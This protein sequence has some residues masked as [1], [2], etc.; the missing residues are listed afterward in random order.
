MKWWIGDGDKQHTIINAD[1]ENAAMQIA[2]DTFGPD[3]IWK[4]MTDEQAAAMEKWLGQLDDAQ[5]HVNQ[6][7]K[8]LTREHNRIKAHYKR[9]DVP[10]L[11]FA[12]LGNLSH[13]VRTDDAT[14]APFPE[15]LDAVMAMV[16]RRRDWAECIARLQELIW[17]GEDHAGS[18]IGFGELRDLFHEGESEPDP[19]DILDML[20]DWYRL[21]SAHRE[22]MD[23]MVLAMHATRPAEL[24]INWAEY[25][26]YLLCTI[27][28]ACE[29]DENLVEELGEIIDAAAEV[30]GGF[31]HFQHLVWTYQ[32]IKARWG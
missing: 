13:C 22:A 5:D 10:D 27:A 6:L 30:Q 21:P 25:Y 11:V 12:D 23:R 24:A 14:A 20:A 1:T 28:A 18:E 3:A 8:L 17:V 29:L 19:N 9:K 2:R 16:E 15:I 7:G 4:P 32:A 26:A 31:S